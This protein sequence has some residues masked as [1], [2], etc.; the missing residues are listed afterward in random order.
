MFLVD[1]LACGHRELRSPR[2]LLSFANTGRG[3][4]L[5]VP[6]TRCGVEVRMATGRAA[7][8][9]APAAPVA[10]VAPVMVPAG[11]VAA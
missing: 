9:S 6:C 4:E 10:P 7:D 2:A 8:V 3:I 5:A 11:H 1:C